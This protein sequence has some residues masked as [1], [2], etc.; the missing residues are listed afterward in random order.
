M[1]SRLLLFTLAAIPLA[2]C[3]ASRSAPAVAAVA[4]SMR[5][6]AEHAQALQAKGFV[7]H[8]DLVGEIYETQSAGFHVT[9]KIDFAEG[10]EAWDDAAWGANSW[11][12]LERDGNQE[13]GWRDVMAEQIRNGG[14]LWGKETTQQLLAWLD[15]FTQQPLPKIELVTKAAEE[16]KTIG[17]LSFE[18]S[19]Q[20]GSDLPDNQFCRAMLTWRSSAK[21]KFDDQ[22]PSGYKSED[23]RARTQ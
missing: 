21:D 22:Y 1:R 8:R 20:R 15:R 11:F 7:H 5:P 18:F 6:R 16:R 13:A 23:G 9:W 14:P 3:E 4:P 17:D 10:Q 2:G 12:K 19:V